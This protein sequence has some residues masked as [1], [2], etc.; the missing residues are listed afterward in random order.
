MGTITV[1]S[2]VLICSNA[3]R[4]LGDDP[5]TSFTDPTNR[6]R[7]CQAIYPKTRDA[8]LRD[9]A[10]NRAV[11]RVA[12]AEL[13]DP[14]AFEFA[15]AYAL[16][17]DFIRLLDTDLDNRRP[18]KIEGDAVVTDATSIKIKYISRLTD[19]TKFDDMFTD[20][21]I[22]RMAYELAQAVTSKQSLSQQ[23]WTEYQDKLK[24]AKAVDGQDDD[25]DTFEDTTLV[26]FRHAG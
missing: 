25:P 18:H 20:C 23:F 16:P 21:L 5:I 11:K 3:L 14:P 12:L 17:S 10:W 6:A 4:K 22:A 8:V 19:T 15:H 13:V 7:L 26:D 24:N 9:H 2:E 1:T